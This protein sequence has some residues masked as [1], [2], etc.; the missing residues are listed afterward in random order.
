M[1]VFENRVLRRIFGHK[2]GEVTGDWRKLHNEELT[3]LFL[4]P[5]I[6]QVIKLRRI[7]W[8]GHVA[9]MGERKGAYR[10]LMGNLR[11]RVHFED[12][13]IDERFI[14]RWLFRKLDWV[15]AWIELIW[16]RIGAGGGLL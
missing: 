1:R 9:H 10:V 2:R 14:L 6:I 5:N 13:G 15:T 3:D 11:E 7:R 16:L 4:S 12:P 8:L